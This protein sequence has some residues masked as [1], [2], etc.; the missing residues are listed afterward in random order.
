[1]LT[2]FFTTTPVTDYDT[3]QT[4]R[5]DLF[6]AFFQG[7]LA[8]GIYLPPSQFEAAF[9]CTA[10]TREDIDQIVE[11]AGRVLAGLKA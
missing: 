1:M 8:Q 6:A 4:C 2:V 11:A 5:T 9:L 10:H 7:M 3:A